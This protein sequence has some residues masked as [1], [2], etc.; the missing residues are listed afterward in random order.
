MAAGILR[1]AGKSHKVD[2]LSCGYMGYTVRQ[3]KILWG[4]VVTRAGLGVQRLA[5]DHC[6]TEGPLRATLRLF[7]LR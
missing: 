5:V 2:Y 6:A 4:K 7:L 1:T 3:F